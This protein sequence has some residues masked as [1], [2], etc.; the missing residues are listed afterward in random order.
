MQKEL[1]Q[2]PKIE[3]VGGHIGYEAGAEMVKRFYDK[4]PEQQYGNIAGRDI[5][6]KILAQ[7]DCVGITILPA[8]NEA[9]TRQTVLVGV[10]SQGQ[11]IL[12]LNVINVTGQIVSEEG[13]VADGFEKGWLGKE[14]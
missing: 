7:P 4:H 12:N 8:Y 10:D 11:P 14:Y 9:G 1:L 13:I 5:I 3:T 6:E 2:N